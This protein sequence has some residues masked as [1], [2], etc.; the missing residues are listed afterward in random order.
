M[1]DLRN[2]VLA[3][4]IGCIGAG[5]FNALKGTDIM[6]DWPVW[7]T[8][9]PKPEPVPEPAPDTPG[10]ELG[11]LVPEKKHRAQLKVFFN[12]LAALVEA[13]TAGALA[14]TDQVREA[15]NRA[16]MLLVQAG[17]WPANANLRDEL[18]RRQSA[19]FGVESK[20]ITATERAAIA[21]FYRS[22]AKEF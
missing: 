9:A 6:P 4:A 2:I 10:G 18:E 22:L 5:G 8:P 1:N 11:K 21:A 7:P 12:D 15:Q 20:P 14:S 16:S 19:A 3:I 13:D 17:K